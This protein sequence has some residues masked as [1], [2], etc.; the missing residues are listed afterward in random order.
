[1]S[2]LKLTLLCIL[3][4]C[5][6][7]ACSSISASAAECKH[8]GSTHGYC[9]AGQLLT[10]SLPVLGTSGL[11][12]LKS[13]ITGAITEIDCLSDDFTGFIEP[14]GHSDAKILFLHCSLP[15]PANCKLTAKQEADIGTVLLLDQLILTAGRIEDL[16]IPKAGNTF[17][18]IEIE[19]KET[20]CVLAKPAETKTF[21]LTG[22]QRCEV[23]A[24][25]ATA[26]T[27]KLTHE[28]ICKE[29]GSELK[30][31]TEPVKFTSTAQIMLENDQLW[32]IGEL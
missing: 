17:T 8:R 27:E 6:L 21:E 7:S 19:G 16:F 3:S 1:M 30:F 13:K 14:N 26:E 24:N 11:S 12:I 22:Q 5:A 4:T 29:S 25:N 2:R 28:L 31:G 10:T 18:T 32:S 9:V 23:N 20:S 15:K